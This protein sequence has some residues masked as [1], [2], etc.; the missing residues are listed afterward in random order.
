MRCELISK[1][2]TPK[3]IEE[4]FPILSL[5]MAA[6]GLV[7]DRSIGWIGLCDCYGGRIAVDDQ[8]CVS[9]FVPRGGGDN[10]MVG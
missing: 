1:D 3:D 4:F 5:S 9:D 2:K 10:R 6:Q 8:D 7:C